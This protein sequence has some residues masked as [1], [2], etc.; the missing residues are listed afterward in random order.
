[1]LFAMSAEG[2]PAV[3]QL[4]LGANQRGG[5]G[6]SLMVVCNNTHRNAKS[7]ARKNPSGCFKCFC[8]KLIGFGQCSKIPTHPA[9]Y[10][11]LSRHGSEKFKE[12]NKTWESEPCFRMFACH[13]SV[14][15]VCGHWYLLVA[16]SSAAW[17]MPMPI[18][19]YDTVPC[20]QRWAS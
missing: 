13:L 2:T 15:H 12:R 20:R 19:Q 9:E 8:I 1:M 5:C 4:S 18:C 3:E 11:G 16:L 17:P 7:S 6:Q 10:P 14:S